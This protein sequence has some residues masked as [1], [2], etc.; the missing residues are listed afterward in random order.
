MSDTWRIIV[1]LLIAGVLIEAVVLVALMRQVGEL[2]LHG[3]PRTRGERAAWARGRHHGGGTW[4]QA[5][6]APGVGALHLVRL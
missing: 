3:G 5:G 1:V 2:L 4:A 6:G